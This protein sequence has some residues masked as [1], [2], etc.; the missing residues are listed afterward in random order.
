M[1][2]QC[3]RCGYPKGPDNEKVGALGSIVESKSTPEFSLAGIF[4]GIA[5]GLLLVLILATQYK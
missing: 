1:N 2:K 4:I 5:I 3:P